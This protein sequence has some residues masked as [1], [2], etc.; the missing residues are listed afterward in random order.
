MSGRPGKVVLALSSIIAILLAECSDNVVQKGGI[1]DF[2]ISIIVLIAVVSV[3]IV[4][5]NPSLHE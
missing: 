1:I 2:L 4:I 3:N 5:S